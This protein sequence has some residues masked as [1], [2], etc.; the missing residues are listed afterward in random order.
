MS[1]DP[2]IAYVVDMADL[3]NPPQRER[4]WTDSEIK[5]LRTSCASLM[6]DLEIAIQLGRSENAVHIKRERLEIPAVR[7]TPGWMST[8][9]VRL[10]LGMNDARPVIGWIRKGLLLGRLLPQASTCWMVHEVSLRR[11]VTRPNNWPYFDAD[12]VRDRHLFRLIKIA[13]EKWGDEW[14]T[15]RRAADLVGEDL[16]KINLYIKLGRLESVSTYNRDG[17]RNV[18]KEPRWSFNYV[19]RS[20]VLAAK[21]DYTYGESFN[22]ATERG[23]E[24]IS[25]A[26]G[27][28]WSNAAIGRSMKIN[29]TTVFN[30]I[31]K[32]NIKPT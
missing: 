21:W 15:T 2:L 13:Q 19:R 25:K 12:A 11:F 31:R 24:W 10:R 17:R 14:L 26:L 3:T 27:K 28:G 6:T 9:K 20:Q 29:H 18:N 22:K 4:E 5:T 30:W 7:N 32:Y 1:I 16:R 8:N 23:L